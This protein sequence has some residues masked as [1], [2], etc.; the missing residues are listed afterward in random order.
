MKRFAFAAALLVTTAAIAQTGSLPGVDKAYM[1]PSVKP[2]DN[3][4]TYANGGWR[5]TAEIPADR[6]SIGVGLD[7][8]LRAEAR[9]AA[10]IKGAA[11]TKG[12][13]GSDQQR[14]AD[15]YAAYTDTDGIE[16]RGLT[17]IQASLSAIAAI[18]N[19]SDL[20]RAIGAAMRVYSRLSSAT[21]RAA[22]AA[23]RLARASRSAFCFSSKSR[24]AMA[25]SASN[26]SPRATSAPV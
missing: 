20:S 13:P 14:I 18:K 10:I 7:V 1:D 2:G 23:C 6:S 17:P 12:A 5:K 9:T 16:A 26:R 11:A 24:R 4:D 19:K 21:L 3:F 8:S 25:L 22:L 15:Y